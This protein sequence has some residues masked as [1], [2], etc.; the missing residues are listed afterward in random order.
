[1]VRP[2]LALDAPVLVTLRELMFEAMGTPAALLAGSRWRPAALAWF[3]AA[4]ADPDIRVVVA[5]IGGDVVSCGVGEVTRLIPGPSTPNGAV[6]L[7]SNIATVP[8]ARGQGLASACLDALLAWFDAETAVTRVDLFATPGGAVIY[9]RR[10]FTEGTF[11]AMR[12]PSPVRRP[13]Y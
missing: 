1:M 10:G 3:E 5:Q 2:A 4:S 6:G 12:R 9:E 8:A 13:P 11:P 7:V